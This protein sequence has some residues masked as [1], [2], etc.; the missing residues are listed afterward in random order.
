MGSYAHSCLEVTLAQLLTGRLPAERARFLEL[1]GKGRQLRG[2][3]EDPGLPEDLRNHLRAA[4]AEQGLAL[5]DL[6]CEWQTIGGRVDLGVSEPVGSAED[7]ETES[8]GSPGSNDG[9]AAFSCVPVPVPD[10]LTDQSPESVEP[11]AAGPIRM[12]IAPRAD[13]HEPLRALVRDLAVQRAPAEEIAFCRELACDAKRLDRVV[14]DGARLDALSFLVARARH[15]C[16][17]RM[18][19]EDDLMAVLSAVTAYARHASIGA[20]YGPSRVHA[21]RSASWALDATIL[22]NRL[23]KEAEVDLAPPN[24]EKLLGQ[25]E[26]LVSTGGGDDE[27]RELVLRCLDAGVR[28]K[29]ARLS[30]IL[31]PVLHALDGKRFKDVRAAVRE[32][33]AEESDADDVVPE[34]VI[35]EGWPLRH[36]TAGKRAVMVGGES[37]E[38][39]RR[40]IQEAF[41]FVSLE[42]TQT[43][44]KKRELQDLRDR[45]TRRS[46]DM[47]ILLTAFVGHSADDIVQPA[48]QSAG[49][50]F[51]PV[52]TGY[53]IVGI[54]SAIERHGSR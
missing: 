8:V 39:N 29:D 1:L 21:S 6:L 50:P 32:R 30:R 25:L 43:E 35:P 37:R 46:V 48:C 44:F 17:K 38:P 36:L 31:L 20:V 7:P 15:L 2:W 18:V 45:V 52:H 54:R 16:D 3:I 13:P 26:T 12:P 41:G 34:A 5:L 22:L 49:V 53:G 27:I 11:A 33:I 28:Q 24:P 23:A 14:P 40:R 4:R 51:V 19:Q 47:V 42:W 9:V 10:D